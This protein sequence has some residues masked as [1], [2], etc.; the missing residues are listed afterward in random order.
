MEN[1]PL[2][3]STLFYPDTSSHTSSIT[4]SSLNIVPTTTSYVPMP[5]SDPSTEP[6]IAQSTGALLPIIATASGGV[7]VIIILGSIFIVIVALLCKKRTSGMMP[8][9]L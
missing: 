2:P 6:T 5:S 8:V 1:I 4:P 7:L 9:V 3:T